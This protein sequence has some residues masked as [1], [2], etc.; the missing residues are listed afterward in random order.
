MMKLAAMACKTLLRMAMKTSERMDMMK[1]SVMLWKTPARRA[2]IK[3]ATVRMQKAARKQKGLTE[4]HAMQSWSWAPAR[5]WKWTSGVMTV[6]RLGEKTTWTSSTTVTTWTSFT[7]VAI[8]TS[9]VIAT[10]TRR[11]RDRIAAASSR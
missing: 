4:K 7:T 5:S 9:T 1:L 8:G 10:A 3:S 2:V 11:A 6:A